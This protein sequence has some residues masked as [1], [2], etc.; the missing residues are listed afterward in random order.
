M[1]AY[2]KGIIT[3][4]NAE[5]VVVEAGGIGY[6]VLATSSLCT[7]CR[8]GEMAQVF[9]YQ[10]VKEDSITLYGFYTRE[11]K[12]MFLRMITVS[13]VGPKSA[14][15]LLGAVSPQDIAVALVTGDAKMLTKAPGIGNKTAQRMILEL[16]EKV[17]N[18]EL[19]QTEPAGAAYVPTDDSAEAVTALMALG[20]PRS[21]A[22]RV[23]QSVAKQATGVEDMIRLALKSMDKGK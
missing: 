16:R 17:K 14:L 23:I 8:I 1:Y 5:S 6:Q 3:E 21:E 11:E 13:G 2:I 10:A 7:N 4:I 18:E 19:I 9:V 22:V 15:Q 12:S 20:I